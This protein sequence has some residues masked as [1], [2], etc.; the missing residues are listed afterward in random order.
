M[1]ASSVDFDKFS[2]IMDDP[3]DPRI[4]SD[5]SR[6]DSKLRI[7]SGVSE[8]VTVDL[9]DGSYL[10]GSSEECDL[11][12]DDKKVESNHLFLEVKGNK[13]TI[14]PISTQLF[15]GGIPCTAR[16]QIKFF[17]VVIVGET[18]FCIGPR[19]KPWP[20]IKSPSLADIDQAKNSIVEKKEEEKAVV[21]QEFL[22]QREES[23]KKTTQLFFPLVMFFCVILAIFSFGVLFPVQAVTETTGQEE[24]V[25]NLISEENLEGSVSLQGNNSSGFVLSGYSADLGAVDRL[26]TA[27]L[28]K[29]PLVK[30]RVW[31]DTE[32]LSKSRKVLKSLGAD[33]VSVDL[34]EAGVLETRGY[35]IE[36]YEWEHISSVLAQDTPDVVTIDDK[37]VYTL[38]QILRRIDQHIINN[39][40]SQW[41]NVETKLGEIIA[42]GVLPGDKYS[43]WA[44][45]L[46]NFNQQMEFIV[47]IN[48]Q[49]I[50][51]EDQRIHLPIRSISIGDVSYLTLQDNSKY[52]EGS[53]IADGFI[54]QSIHLDHIEVSKN[55]I[56]YDYYL[57]VENEQ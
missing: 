24:G 2:R 30:M 41:V 46:D 48:D 6:C 14:C 42:T 15:I 10:L 29:Y 26:K 39:E 13:I 43:L 17:D 19:R 54:L 47:D 1:N 51:A 23:A 45:T 57:G 12:I 5:E 38:A 33:H 40:L 32:L 27:V 50:N 11:I 53:L 52:V 35:T 55:N 16:Q 49:V 56:T 21:Q 31:N 7:L 8:G 44:N 20:S 22:K 36:S 18:S 9:Q 4:V 25:N 28:N 37:N 34:T 3:R